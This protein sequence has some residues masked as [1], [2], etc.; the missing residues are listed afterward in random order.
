M[1]RSRSCRRQRAVIMRDL[2]SGAQCAMTNGIE[3]DISISG[4][5]GILAADLVAREV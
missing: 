1:L 4:Q 2:P 3:A 5:G